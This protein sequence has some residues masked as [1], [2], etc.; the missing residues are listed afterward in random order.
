M[1]INLN[2]KRQQLLCDKP[3]PCAAVVFSGRAPMRSADGA[4]PFSM[5]RDFYYLTGIDHENMILVMTKDH[6]GKTSEMLFIE[7]YDEVQA[8]W[9]G[10]RMKPDEATAISGV[11]DI[12]YLD[13]FESAL[14]LM[15]RANRGE[16]E[17]NL[18]LDL[19]KH[20]PEQEPTLAHK[21]AHKVQQEYP[22]VRINDL[23]GDLARMRA[24][25][26]DEEIEKMKI[27]QTTTQH[28]IEAMM[29][30][31]YPGI[32]ESELEGAFDFELAKQG[33]REH[34]FSSIVA[35][36]AR[37]TVLHYSENNQVVNDG[38]LVLIDLG[39]AH[40]H[41]CADIS[42]TFPVNGKFTERQK[43]VYNV[44]LAVQD[45][46]IEKARPGMTLMDLN[47]MVIEF[48][49]QELPKIGL[50]KDGKNRSGLSQREPGLGLDCHDVTTPTT[51][52]LR[53]GM[54]ITVEPGLYIEE[55]GIGV[56]IE[57]DIII[58]EEKPI[59]LSSNILKTVEDIEALMAK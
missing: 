57:N 13:T 35:G 17:T 37:A 52:T 9:V 33:V 18:W 41:Y 6:Y 36:G 16:G 39:S 27:A 28:A 34:A 3:G 54:V 10:G 45:L 30:H 40:E 7:P 2:Q 4:Y 29:K 59:D 48:Y 56:R 43:E 11:Q 5:D 25:K 19:W 1:N 49:E 44:V 24:I 20:T 14:N 42:R 32:N 21:L 50:L 47:N 55:E 12:R 23:F 26:S 46:I 15:I 58:T 53:P 8:K 38:E 22:A 51:K 31:S